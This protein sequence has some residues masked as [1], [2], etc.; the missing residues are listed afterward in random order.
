MK[1][2]VEALGAGKGQSGLIQGAAAGTKGGVAA[3]SSSAL[4]PPA[5]SCPL[6]TPFRRARLGLLSRLILPGLLLAS[7]G[8]PMHSEYLRLQAKAHDGTLSP[9]D[10]ITVMEAGSPPLHATVGD[11]GILDLGELGSFQVNSRT[12]RSL[13]DQLAKDRG[14]ATT[15]ILVRSQVPLAGRAFVFG[16]VDKPGRVPL[17]RFPT[18]SAAVR[19][20]MPAKELADVRKV[21]LLRGEIPNER[22]MVFSLLQIERG[23]VDPVLMDGDILVVPATPLGRVFGPL[24]S[25]DETPQPQNSHAE[26]PEDKSASRVENL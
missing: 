1:G 23:G 13:R 16:Q 5:M 14:L 11:N 24:R 25:A 15:Q 26:A 6:P 3:P 10:Q 12:P 4:P 19:Q 22:E 18:L 21:R 9:G 20:A 8:A 2:S 17:T 7:C